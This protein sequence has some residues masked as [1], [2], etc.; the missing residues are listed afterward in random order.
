M[1]GQVELGGVLEALQ[2]LSA[3]TALS[4]A[5]LAAAVE[6]AVAETYRRLVEDDPAVRA[7]FDPARG[8]FD[9]YRREE[10]GT[11]QPVTVEVRDFS[12]QAAAAARSA[13][14]ER[15]VEADR[16]RV[17]DEADARHGEL[18]DAIVE[19]QAGPAWYLSV[20][21]APGLLPPDEQIPGERLTPHVHVKVVVLEGRRRLH[22]AVIVVSRSH[23]LLL[24]RL[25]EQEV[26]ELMSGQVVVRGI[27]REPGR[28]SK[29]AVD[30]PAGDIDPQGACIGPR[31][32][33]HRAV[34]SELGQEQVQIVMWS[35]DPAAFVANALT[36]AA[37]TE[38]TI[39]PETR[40][41][42]VKVP[43][44]QL[45]LAIGRGGENARLVARL[46]GLRIDI[47]SA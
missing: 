22:D 16:R 12:R 39:D 38:V 9:L 1:P 23:P 15:L 43:P 31:G 21:G 18:V 26:P 27:A 24:Q 5:E 42:R 47:A 2:E 37:A 10:S 33:R 32:V 28:R 40:T 29:V 13:V 25:L 35:P 7:R 46:C 19:R 45:S 17:L 20:G 11:E 14:S 30:A 41:A 6:E 34:T 4:E 3:E 8:S 44:E 36:P